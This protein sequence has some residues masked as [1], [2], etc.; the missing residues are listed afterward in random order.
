M[1]YR[2]ILPVIAVL[3]LMA[4]C[5]GDVEKEIIGEWK[6]MTAKQDLFFHEGG[7]IDMKGHNHG[8]YEGEYIIEEGDKLTCTFVRLSKPVQC[9]A[10]IQ[11]DTLTLT[12]PSGREEVYERK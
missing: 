5:G 3:L 7:R 6:G 1:A 8:V 9:T 4:G 10:S 11:G 12:F 2:T